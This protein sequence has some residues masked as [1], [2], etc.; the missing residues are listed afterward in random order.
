VHYGAARTMQHSNHIF[1]TAHYA[2]A[3]FYVYGSAVKHK[4]IAQN[5]N[6]LSI[7]FLEATSFWSNEVVTNP[8]I[9]VFL[10]K[11]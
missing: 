6:Q 4:H 1:L 2:L 5:K 9:S 8:E 3:F 10:E 7:V 11:L